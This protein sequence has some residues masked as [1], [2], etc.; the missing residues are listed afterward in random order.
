MLQFVCLQAAE[1]G[2]SEFQVQVWGETVQ[3]MYSVALDLVGV[4]P[5]LVVVK[6]P[7]TIEGIQAASLLRESSV[8]VTITGIFTSSQVLMAQSVGAAY[9]APY[10]GRMNDA[11]GDSKVCVCVCVCVWAYVWGGAWWPACLLPVSLSLVSPIG[12]SYS[13]PPP[14]ALLRPSTPCACPFAF[15]HPHTL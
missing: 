10:L 4:N 15:P 1:L 13:A 11:Y 5:K 7:C 12:S 14:P 6:L 8:R 9:A 2:A 3:K